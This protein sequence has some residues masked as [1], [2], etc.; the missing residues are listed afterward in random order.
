LI[1]FGDQAVPYLVQVFEHTNRPSWAKEQPTVSQSAKIALDRIGTPAALE[2]AA[3]WD[4][5]E[6]YRINFLKI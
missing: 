4:L 1:G 2:A 3:A 5:P 6:E